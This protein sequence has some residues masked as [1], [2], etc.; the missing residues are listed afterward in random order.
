MKW[1]TILMILGICVA[2]SHAQSST[3]GSSDSEW[4]Y[5]GNDFGEQHYS[6]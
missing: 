6:R 3:P 2:S 4:F 5:I 1:V